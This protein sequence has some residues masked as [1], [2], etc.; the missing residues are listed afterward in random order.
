VQVVADDTPYTSAK[1]FEDLKLSPELLQGLYSEMKFEKPSKI[2]AETLPMIVTPPYKN[3]IAQAHNGSGKTTCF[4]LGMLSRVD[5]KMKAP[6]ALCVCPTRELVIQ[7]HHRESKPIFFSGC[8]GFRV[9]G[10]SRISL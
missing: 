4:V 1:S 3:L 8:L 5:P 10:T 2:Q 7:V 6:Q 9:K